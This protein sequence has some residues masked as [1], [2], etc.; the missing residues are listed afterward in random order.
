MKEKIYAMILILLA[1]LRTLIGF[2]LLN[3]V[4]ALC[5]IIDRAMAA[6]MVKNGEYDRDEAEDALRSISE[7]L[8]SNYDYFTGID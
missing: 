6:V 3:P 8:R 5:A 4:A 7:A 1:I 2:I